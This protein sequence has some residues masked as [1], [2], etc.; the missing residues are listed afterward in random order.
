MIDGT[1]IPPVLIDIKAMELVF[2][3]GQVAPFVK[4]AI[5]H[6]TREARSRRAMQLWAQTRA[7]NFPM[8]VDCGLAERN[9]AY[10]YRTT[11]LSLSQ[12]ERLGI[13]FSAYLVEVL[14]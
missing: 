9:A 2:P 8:P 7:N 14:I 4:I 6:N 1:P 13:L 10:L 5:P 12:C 11:S 3:N